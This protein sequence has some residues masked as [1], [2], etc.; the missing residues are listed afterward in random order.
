MAID[1]DINKGLQAALNGN[2]LLF[3][4]AGFSFGATNVKTE[5]LLAGK[6]LAKQIATRCGISD[7][8][9]LDVAAQFFQED[10]GDDELIKLLRSEY[11][12][13]DVAKHHLDLAAVPWSRVYTTNYDNVYEFACARLPRD[14]N[15]I[16]IDKLPSEVALSSNDCVHIN[17]SILGLTRDTI[18][19]SLKLTRTS[20]LTDA[21]S[22]NAWVDVF[23][24]DV[25]CAEAFF[26]IGYSLYDLDINRILYATKTLRKK[27]FFV[28]SKSP[29]SVE[30][31]I[32]SPFGSLAPIGIDGIA[33]YLTKTKATFTPVTTN[34]LPLASFDTALPPS[35]KPLDIRDS[36]VFNLLFY[37]DVNAEFVGQSIRKDTSEYTIKRRVFC[38]LTNEIEANSK[39]IILHTD[40]GNGKSILVEQLRSWAHIENRDIFVFRNRSRSV[41]HEI[42]QICSQHTSPIIVFENY[43]FWLDLI[44]ETQSRRPATSTLILTSRSGVHD[45]FNRDLHEIIGDHIEIDANILRPEDVTHLSEFLTA[46]GMWGDFADLSTREK[47]DFIRKQCGATIH[48]VLLRLLESRTIHERLDKA[49]NAI[50]TNNDI[51]KMVISILILRILNIAIDGNLLLDILGIDA[52]ASLTAR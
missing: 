43:E 42:Q 36:D 40:L 5:K 1:G 13:S 2:A 15:P 6:E 25:E 26:F 24:S 49:I 14:V 51:Y 52:Q 29:S 7:E 38:E 27:T 35:K 11:T 21:F 20:Y 34:E 9:E 10:H 44:K 28:V 19:S 50:K 37:G 17:G 31:R 30:K 39:T 16:T 23:R 3:T 48:A 41:L 4:G 22:D 12:V 47:E 46:Y 33:S 32:F 8:L 45:I 18:H